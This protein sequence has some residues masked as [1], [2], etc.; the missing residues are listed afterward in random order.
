M[1]PDGRSASKMDNDKLYDGFAKNRRFLIVVSLALS[2]LGALGLHV[3][4]VDVLGNKASITHPEHL[5]Y[6]AVAV[7]LWAY[8]QYIFW[9]RDIEAVEMFKKA[10]SE[11]CDRRI[12]RM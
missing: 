2:C 12:W 3:G 11:T 7:W 4:E 10:I 6:L 9:F 8:M 1:Y 5:T